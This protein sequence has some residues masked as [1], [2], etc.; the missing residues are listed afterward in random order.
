MYL[1]FYKSESPF[2]Q[3]YSCKFT[4]SN[5]I[6]YTS[7]EQYMMYK[8]A[9]LFNDLGI[10]NKILSASNPKLIKI[11]GRQVKNFDET[12]WKKNRENIVYQGNLYKFTQNNLLKKIMLD[13]KDKILVEASPYDK[14]WGI[15]MCK[16]HKDINDKSKWKGLNLLGK[17]L[18]KVRSSIK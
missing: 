6:N 5:S 13:T 4:D 15:G 7:S 17:C 2:S 11:Y 16:T 3:W 14:I 8:K 1:F 9:I 10:A 12:L 18:M